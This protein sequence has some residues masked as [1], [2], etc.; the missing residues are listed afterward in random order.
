MIAKTEQSRHKRGHGIAEE[1]S[2]Y[3]NKVLTHLEKAGLEA[4]LI[5]GSVQNRGETKPLLR[6]LIASYKW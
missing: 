4:S 1:L 5:F 3:N 2:I 6:W